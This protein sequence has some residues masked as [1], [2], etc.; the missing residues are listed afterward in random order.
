M[1]IPNVGFLFYKHYYRNERLEFDLNNIKERNNA[2]L[3]TKFNKIYNNPYGKHYF[4][5]KTIYPGMLIGIGYHHGI[6]EVDD[7][8]IGFYFDYT[9][10]LPVI[11]GSTVKGLLRSA[12]KHR[13]YICEILKNENINF[14]ESKV[15]EFK[16][17]LKGNDKKD[18][19]SDV[20]LSISLLE[21]EI[22]EVGT[23]E[24]FKDI[25][26]EAYIYE[27]LGNKG[28]FLADDY[29]TPHFRNPLKE[30]KP[31]KFIKILP[32]VV[33]RFNFDLNDGMINAL[34]KLKLFRQILLDL[35]IGAKTN[36][37][38]GKFDEWYGKKDILNLKKE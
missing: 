38:Y 27:V 2:I 6:N 32:D 18:Y 15:E 23:A 24:G 29:I 8:K 21:Y 13:E 35:G 31:I 20:E 25:F 3:S 19:I 10:G 14:N 7:Y 5:L 9:T 11:P 17:F 4:R 16:K 33:F 22:F 28:R 26:Y 12:F 34:D 30:P 1:I 37:G 36:V